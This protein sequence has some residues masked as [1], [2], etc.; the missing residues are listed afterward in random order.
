MA[1]FRA[2]G[3]AFNHKGSNRAL[4]VYQRETAPAYYLSS[5]ISVSEQKATAASFCFFQDWHGTAI[6]VN[7]RI[8]PGGMLLYL[9]KIPYA[10]CRYWIDRP[11]APYSPGVPVQRDAVTTTSDSWPF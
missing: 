7:E 10:A 5:Y 11:S 9:A 6:M 3:L 4:A 2:P 1:E 8:P